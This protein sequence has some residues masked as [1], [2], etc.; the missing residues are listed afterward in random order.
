MEKR[1]ADEDESPC[2]LSADVLNPHQRHAYLYYNIR[3]L[4]TL[5]QASKSGQNTEIYFINTHA[6]SMIKKVSQLVLREV[7]EERRAVRALGAR[8]TLPPRVLSTLQEKRISRDRA[9]PETL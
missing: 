5:V 8:H 9:S 4:T 1:S 6:H 7:N 3:I 2:R